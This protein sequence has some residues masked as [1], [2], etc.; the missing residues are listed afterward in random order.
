MWDASVV[1]WV[2]ASVVGQRD[3][4]AIGSLLE[5]WWDVIWSD[6]WMRRFFAGGT[7]GCAT[8]IKVVLNSVLE[9]CRLHKKCGTRGCL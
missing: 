2:D 3:E 6:D 1:G 8:C 7:R 4:G 5:C 9:L